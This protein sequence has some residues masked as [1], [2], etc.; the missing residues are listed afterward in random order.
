MG[1]KHRAY[2]S[3]LN[4]GLE[5]EL[6]LVTVIKCEDTLAVDAHHTRRLDAV[7][8][9]LGSGARQKRNRE[10]RVLLID[11]NQLDEMAIPSM[12]DG[13]GTMTCRMFNDER[14]RIIPTRIHAGGSIGEH[15]QES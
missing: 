1:E 8:L 13:T 15:A 11:S 2:C 4:F 12:N 9:H 5:V 14:C 7:I 3:N 10:R 6:Q